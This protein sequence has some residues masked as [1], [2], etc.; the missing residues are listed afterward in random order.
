MYTHFLIDAV[1]AVAVVVSKA[2]YYGYGNGNV[3]KQKV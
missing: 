1:L 2:P 3:A